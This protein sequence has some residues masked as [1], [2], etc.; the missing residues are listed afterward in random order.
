MSVVSQLLF[1]ILVLGLLQPQVL[2]NFQAKTQLPRCFRNGAK[3]VGRV[4]LCNFNYSAILWD[5][6]PK[7]DWAQKTGWTLEKSKL[8]S[9]SYVWCNCFVKYL[10]FPTFLFINPARKGPWSW[11]ILLCFREKKNLKYSLWWCFNWKKWC[12]EIRIR[13]FLP[14]IRKCQRFPFLGCFT[15]VDLRRQ[16]LANDFFS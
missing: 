12:F 9:Q 4:L 16:M 11:N 5:I 14:R 6:L 15:P 1:H 7:W 2:W 8:L 10:L 13:H 3:C